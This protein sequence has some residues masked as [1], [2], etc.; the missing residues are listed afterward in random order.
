MNAI[1]T[2]FLLLV[3]TLILIYGGLALG[4]EQGMTFALLFA[5]LMNFGAFFWSDKIALAMSGARPVTPEQAP[6]LY[7]LTES[8]CQRARAADAAALRHPAGPAQRFRY[9][10]QPAESSRGSDGRTAG[11]DERAGARGRAGA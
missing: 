9:R 8:L 3:L 2:G 10:A 4:G 1:K 5:A 7:R 11:G 6:Q